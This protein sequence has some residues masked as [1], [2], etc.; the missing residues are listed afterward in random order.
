MGV[1]VV[2]ARTNNA[3]SMECP[4]G[5]SFRS[6]SSP[7]AGT[8]ANGEA[9]ALWYDISALCVSVAENPK[10]MVSGRKKMVHTKRL[11]WATK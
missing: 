9:S 1:Q 10:A 4:C 6:V 5:F 11:V 7:P 8:S 3:F 2:A